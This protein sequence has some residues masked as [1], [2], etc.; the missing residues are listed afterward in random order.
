MSNKGEGGLEKGEWKRMRKEEEKGEKDRTGA[1][2]A[3]GFDRACV[4][5]YFHHLAAKTKNLVG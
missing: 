4:W 1:G 3:G 5:S 2:A